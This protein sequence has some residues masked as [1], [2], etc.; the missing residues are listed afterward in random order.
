MAFADITSGAIE[1]SNIKIKDFETIS[2]P[3][4]TQFMLGLD[5]ESNNKGIKIPRTS[6]FQGMIVDDGNNLISLEDVTGKLQAPDKVGDL[7]QLET[8]DKDNVVLAVNELVERVD[9][10]EGTRLNADNG[11][12]QQINNLQAASDVADIVG[13]YQDLLDYDTSTLFDNN[14]IKVLDD[15]THDRKPSYYRWVITSGTGSFVYIG[16]E[17]I[18]Q[19][20]LK[21]L[22]GSGSI[23]LEDNTAYLIE[24]TG[25]V[26]FTLPSITD[27][28]KIHQIFMQ[29][30]MDNIYTITLSQYGEDLK[31]FGLEE[32]DFSRAGN[33]NLYY[34]FDNLNQNWVCGALQKGNAE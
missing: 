3:T 13:T 19:I 18:G 17:N 6:L 34:E 30:K 15:E 21:T 33:Y 23:E 1:S 14:I 24:V 2:Q 9:V 12:Q 25:N 28:S 27:L 11:L 31:Y 26:S 32:V 10:E 5:S 4:E 16:T 29:I 8:E 20:P 7:T 22:S